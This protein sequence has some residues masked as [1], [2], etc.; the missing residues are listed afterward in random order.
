MAKK[1]S[2]KEYREANKKFI[3]D[4]SRQE[5]VLPLGNDV[6]YKVLESGEGKG[7]VKFNSVVTC[8]YRGRRIDGYVFD[9]SFERPIPEAF[10]CNELIP[11]FSAA[12]MKMHIGD[13]WEVYIPYT[14]AYGTRDD[15]RIPGYSTL[16]FEIL[17]VGIA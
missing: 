5:G 17:L 13:R 3:E 7:E 12:L 2:R 15:G 16:I 10:R 11:G 1:E 9:S 6:Y 14:E 8:H 4:I